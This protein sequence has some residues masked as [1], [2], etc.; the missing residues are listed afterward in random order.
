EATVSDA[1][2]VLGRL[3][4]QTRLAGRLSLDLDAARRA[5]GA[6]GDALGLEPEAAAEGIIQ[7]ANEHMARALRAI[8]V[9]RGY[10]SSAFRLCCFGGAGGLHVCSLAKAL[11]MRRA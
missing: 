5:V 3:P 9:E 1:N 6:L 2:A 8:S 10:D 7:L 11:G 4:A